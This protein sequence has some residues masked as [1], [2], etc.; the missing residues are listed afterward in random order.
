MTD[1]VLLKSAVKKSPYKIGFIAKKCDLSRSGLNNKMNGK[2]QF[3][4]FEIGTLC[5]LLELDLLE[6]E[7]IFF[8]K[9]V[10]LKET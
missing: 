1:I 6:R 5:E 4:Q 10:S 9:K 2:Q 3:N 8:A 7:R